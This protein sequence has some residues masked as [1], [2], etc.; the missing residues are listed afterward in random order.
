MVYR[1]LDAEPLFDLNSLRPNSIEA[2]EYYVG[3]ASTPMRY[4]RMNS[5]CGVIV[6]H[7]RRTP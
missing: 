3:P 7:T 5:N 6:I 4:A 2:I 1:G